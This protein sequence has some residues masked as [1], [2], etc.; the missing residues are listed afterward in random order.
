MCAHLEEAEAH[1]GAV[2]GAQPLLV[3]GDDL[4]RL[5]HNL[6]VNH[7]LEGAVNWVRL[8]EIGVDWAVGE[9]RWRTISRWITA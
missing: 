2:A 9:S 3:H 6:A 8:G 4:G 5:A 1:A 7:R